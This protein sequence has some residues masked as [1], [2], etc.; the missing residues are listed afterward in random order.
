MR[1]SGQPPGGGKPPGVGWM[2]RGLPVLVL[3]A[4]GLFHL[5]R[6][7]LLD[8]LIFLTAVLMLVLGEVGDGLRLWTG[9]ARTAGRP[10]TLARVAAPQVA[11]GRR[12]P[13]APGGAQ[14]ARAWPVV[15]VVVAAGY[16]WAVGQWLGTGGSAWVA[17]AVPGLVALAYAWSQ[18]AP[19]GR[20]VMPAG[21][22]AWGGVAVAAAV[23]EVGSYVLQQRPI[24]GRL[25]HHPTISVLVD[26]VVEASPGRQLGLA[27]WLAGGYLLLRRATAVNAPTPGREGGS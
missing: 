16:G 17:I 3:A 9:R 6:G 25:H 24:P 22:L 1:P 5:W 13:A 23:W 4:T 10:R 15:V 2:P 19:R 27:L 14:R 8:A 20:L 26:P 7:A 12:T 21:S 18:R 11:A